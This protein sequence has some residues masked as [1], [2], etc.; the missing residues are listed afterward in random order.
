MSTL[1]TDIY[2]SFLE[3]EVTS[4]DLLKYNPPLLSKY[5]NN[6]LERARSEFYNL[7]YSNPPNVNNKMEDITL[8]YLKDYTEESFN[9]SSLTVQLLNDTPIDSLFYITVND[10]ITT[11]YSYDSDTK[12]ITISELDTEITSNI[13][14]YAYRNGIFNQ[15]L[16]LIEK[17]ILVDWMGVIY[18]KDKIKTQKLYNQSIYGKSEGQYSQANHLKELQSIY[19]DNKKSI[20]TKTI[21]YTYRN[22]PDWNRYVAKG[23]RKNT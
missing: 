2:D 15:T 12:I 3:T 4:R 21:E 8:F 7:A 11:N 1:F 14:I 10:D 6:L 9:N 17:D 13:V 20:I 16:T 19:N 18:L 23:V 5:L 22:A